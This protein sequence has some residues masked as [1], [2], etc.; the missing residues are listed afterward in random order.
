MSVKGTH[1]GLTEDVKG[2]IYTALS[3]GC[4][5]TGAMKAAGIARRTF[6]NWLEDVQDFR[7]NVQYAEAEARVAIEARL[8]RLAIEGD[9][10]SIMYWLQNRYPDDWKDTRNYKIDQNI[11]VQEQKIA[12]ATDDEILDLLEKEGINVEEFR[13]ETKSTED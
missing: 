2:I 10:F 13:R 5:R 1:P 9:R 11:A 8:H 12:E 4:T 3:E 7:E 6:Y